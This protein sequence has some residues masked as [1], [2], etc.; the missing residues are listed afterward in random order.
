[1]VLREVFTLTGMS[2][3][4][5]IL[6]AAAQGNASAADQVLPLVYKELRRLAAHYLQ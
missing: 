4:T 5:R 3:L 6:D 1:M 2:D